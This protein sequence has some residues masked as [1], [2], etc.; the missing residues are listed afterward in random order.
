MESYWIYLAMVAILGLRWL[1]EQFKRAAQQRA[2]MRERRFRGVDAEAQEQRAAPPRRVPPPQQQQRE[3]EPQ[4]QAQTVP[5][6]LQELFEQRRQ[7]IAE[8]QRQAAQPKPKP[9]PLRA[10]EPEPKPEV[11]QE[12]PVVLPAVAPIEA[13]YSSLIYGADAYRE[14]SAISETLSDHEKIRSAL[15]LKEILGRPKGLDL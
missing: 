14:K 2:E 4:P 3:P 7:E 6:T 12:Q 9:P 11:R 10:P 8:A 1:I 15:I 5:Q 13:D